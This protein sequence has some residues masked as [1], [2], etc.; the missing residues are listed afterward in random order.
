[1]ALTLCPN[2]RLPVNRSAQRCPLCTKSIPNVATRTR[3]VSVA[4]AA[5]AV[6]ATTVALVARRLA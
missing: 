5:V 3:N 4:A 2:C 1:M 6:A